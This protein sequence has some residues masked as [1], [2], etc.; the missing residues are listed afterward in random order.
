MA[1]AALS[2]HGSSSAQAP[3]GHTPLERRQTDPYLQ[4]HGGT[5]EGGVLP[6]AFAA[7][8]LPSIPPSSAALTN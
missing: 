5:I 6:L 3:T 8:L 1:R 2:V 4:A 7:G